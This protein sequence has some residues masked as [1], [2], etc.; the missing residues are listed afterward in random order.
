MLK[1][2]NQDIF[3]NY[4]SIILSILG[5]VLAVK[6]RASDMG[7]SK[8]CF[9]GIEPSLSAIMLYLSPSLLYSL[10]KIYFPLGI[11]DFRK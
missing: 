5:T 4:H 3:L 1:I 2:A 9:D 6:I 7:H 11:N 8:N 10:V